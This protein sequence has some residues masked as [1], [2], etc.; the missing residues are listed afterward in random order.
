MREDSYHSFQSW[1]R[2]TE[3][4]HGQ[5]L[6]WSATLVC[7]LV[8][9]Q[10][11]S[12]SPSAYQAVHSHLGPDWIIPTAIRW[13]AMKFCTIMF[14]K[15]WI[16]MTLGIPTFPLVPQWNWQLWLVLK[17]LNYNALDWTWYTLIFLSR[18]CNFLSSTIIRWNFLVYDSI[19]AKLMTVPS[20]SVTLASVKRL[21][22]LKDGLWPP[23]SF[24]CCSLIPGHRLWPLLSWCSW[25]HNDN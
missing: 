10:A 22:Q 1:V 16:T 15:G 17:C 14:P 12:L 23:C 13:T 24:S 8:R 21:S 6:R 18:N 5:Q 20:A 4:K 11:L 9:N 7:W 3:M 19:T 2:R 25:S